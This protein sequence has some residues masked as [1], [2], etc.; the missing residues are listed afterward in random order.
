MFIVTVPF[1]SLNKYKYLDQGTLVKS[2]DIYQKDT[3]LNKVEEV[4]EW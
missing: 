2:P 1:L 4:G 3:C